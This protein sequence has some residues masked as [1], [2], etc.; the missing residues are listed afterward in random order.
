MWLFT[1]FRRKCIFYPHLAEIGPKCPHVRGTSAVGSVSKKLPDL[2]DFRNKEALETDKMAGFAGAGNPLANLMARSDHGAIRDYVTG[3]DHLQYSQLAEGEVLVLLTHSNLPA[4]F[5][6]IRLDLHMT[7]ERVKERFKLHIGTPVD[8]QRLILKD[9]GR[10]VCE[11]TDNRKMLGFYSVVPGNEIHVIDTDPYSLSR[12]GGLTDVTLVEKYRMT[13]EA[14]DSRKGTMRD[15]IREQRKKDPNFKLKPKGITTMGVGTATA[16]QQAKIDSF[17]MNE[18]EVPPGAESVEGIE[19]GMRCEVQPG[20]RRGE[21]M[22]VGENAALKAG[23]W[24]GVKLD[25][26]LGMNNGTVKGV[27]LFECGENFGA[28]VRGKN[29]TVG[30]FPDLFGL[31]TDSD[32]EI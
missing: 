5:P 13:D 31:E 3:A 18:Q 17:T 9:N 21:V 2:L 4:K 11:M 20:A 14:Y 12:G 16:D 29:C 32:E 6:D 8:H 26:P 23:Y 1:P 10:V 19:V 28:M 30:D 24:V 7:I 25:E 27:K 22:W 15:F